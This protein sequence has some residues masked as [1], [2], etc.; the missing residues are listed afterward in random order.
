MSENLITAVFTFTL[1]LLT[2]RT[3]LRHQN[4]LI[5]LFARYIYYILM[6][7]SFHISIFRN[8]VPLPG[9][10]IAIIIIGIIGMVLCILSVWKTPFKGKQ[11]FQSICS[12]GKCCATFLIQA[13]LMTF[14]M[15]IALAL[16]I[17]TLI[18]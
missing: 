14:C 16:L 9:R 15:F 2:G 10:N 8:D 3:I 7:F 17:V 6:F 5:G 4:I 11:R 12:T 1:S 18:L 13:N